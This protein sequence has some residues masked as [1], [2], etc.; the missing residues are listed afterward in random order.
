LAKEC[1]EAKRTLYEAKGCAH[2]SESEA[3]ETKPT[4]AKC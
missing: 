1:R 2:C 4:G 3:K